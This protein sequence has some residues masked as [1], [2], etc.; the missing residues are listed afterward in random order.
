[1]ANYAYLT[2]SD[3]GAFTVEGVPL[4]EAVY[5]VPAFWLT[6]FDE[7]CLRTFH[8]E[9]GDIPYLASDL[10]NARLRSQSALRRFRETFRES[11]GY[12]DRWSLWLSELSCVWVQAD[13]SEVV[14][15]ND[16]LHVVKPALRFLE[17]QS[18]ENMT[19]YLSLTGLSDKLDGS[20]L[21]E[22]ESAF[23]TYTTFDRLAGL[24]C[25]AV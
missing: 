4:L 17:N 22:C 15:M 1:M 24:P 10:K 14:S 11:Y 25:H 6:L 2:G 8:D 18:N 3:G 21:V 9:D 12:C 16:D 23:S 5:C 19:A 7:S 13:I 20:I